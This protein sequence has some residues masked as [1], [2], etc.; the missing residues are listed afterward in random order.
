MS[1]QL[2][3][4]VHISSALLTRFVFFWLVL[5]HSWIIVVRFLFLI[6]LNHLPVAQKPSN[7]GLES[8]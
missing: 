1:N 3:V 6:W 8:E 4:I 2:L 5:D 7:I